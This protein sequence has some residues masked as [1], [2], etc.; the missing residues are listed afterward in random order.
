MTRLL[1]YKRLPSH[2][3]LFQVVVK[4]DDSSFRAAGLCSK[5]SGRF[6]G[7]S[8][9]LSLEFRGHDFWAWLTQRSWS[10]LA[11][12]KKDFSKGIMGRKRCVNHVFK[13]RGFQVKMKPGCHTEKL[14]FLFFSSLASLIWRLK[15]KDG[16][17]LPTLSEGSFSPGALVKYSSFKE[18]C[19][20]SQS[21]GNSIAECIIPW[22]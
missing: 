10:Y 8:I 3:H 11:N 5:Y 20:Y 14:I 12:S 2:Y 1:I 4:A 6:T 7:L 15:T 18:K 19:F 22:L 13:Q 17:L 21:C 9:F 16:N